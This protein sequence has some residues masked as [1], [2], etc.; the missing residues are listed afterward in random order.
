MAR[1][2]IVRPRGRPRTF[3]SQLIGIN[4]VKT[5]IFVD[6]ATMIYWAK[7][8]ND[9]ADGTPGLNRMAYEVAQE[10]TYMVVDLLK[11][12]TSDKKVFVPDGPPARAALRG[13]QVNNCTASISSHA[14]DLGVDTTGGGARDAAKLRERATT[15]AGRSERGKTVVQTL[16][17]VGADAKQPK[18]AAVLSRQGMDKSQVYGVSAVGADPKTTSVQKSNL[19]TASGALHKRGL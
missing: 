14:I 1:G 7:S 5:E 16:R 10:W 17:Q 2:L 19:A 6:D 9:K 11:L 15:N 4:G 8:E 18:K 13:C 12:Q 3:C